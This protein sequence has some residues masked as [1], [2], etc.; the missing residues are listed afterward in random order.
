MP[1]RADEGVHRE[2]SIARE[3]LATPRLILRATCEE[4]IGVLHEKVFSDAEVARFVF[5]GRA[6]SLEESATFIRQNFNFAGDDIGL[7]TLVER[8]SGEVIGFSGLGRCR[9]LGAD[10]L[11]VGFV[12]ARPAWGKGYASEIGR[13]QLEL[14][15]RGLG[16]ERL[17]ALAH[18][19]NVRSINVI[20]KMGMRHESDALV[21]G[22]GPRRVYC[23]EA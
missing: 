20:L 23:L 13:A 1:E 6:F 3:I 10:D 14:G 22:R 11:E 15:I 18:P 4:D 21:D 9:V 19:G 12:L 5:A 7:A 17:L 16:R 2:R 8:D